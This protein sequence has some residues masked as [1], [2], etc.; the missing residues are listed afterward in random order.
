M[1]LEEIDDGNSGGVSSSTPAGLADGL[2]PKR[3]PYT[4]PRSDRRYAPREPVPPLPPHFSAAWIRRFRR[5]VISPADRPRNGA[6]ACARRRD[7]AATQRDPLSAGYSIATISSSS[8]PRGARSRTLSPTAAPS[9]ARARG[10]T[11]ASLPRAASASSTPTIWKRRT[12]PPPSTV[13]VAPKRTRSRGDAGRPTTSALAMRASSS[14]RRCAR[15]RGT[16]C[17]PRPRVRARRPRA[18]GPDLRALR[19]GARAPAA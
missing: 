18:R 19:A 4:N 15:R 14:A 2:G 8:S 16:R 11:K 17:G 10:E 6:A 9:S 5:V 13:T 12:P 7:G 1:D 3:L